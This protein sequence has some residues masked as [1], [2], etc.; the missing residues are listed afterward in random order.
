VLHVA[1]VAGG[2]EIA[3]VLVHDAVLVVVLTMVRVG[4]VECS[5]VRFV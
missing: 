4:L 1:A 2:A 5:F 3:G